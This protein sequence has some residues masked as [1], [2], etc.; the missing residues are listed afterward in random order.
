[1]AKLYIVNN[2]S[3]YTGPVPTGFTLHAPGDIWLRN[4]DEVILSNTLSSSVN[5]RPERGYAQS[6]ADP[7]VSLE[8]G[9]HGA[10]NVTTQVWLAREDLSLQI[11]VPDDTDARSVNIS[12]SGTDGSDTTVGSN[13]SIGNVTGGNDSG[14]NDSLTVGD[15]SSVGTINMGNGDNYV[16]IGDN[17]TLNGASNAIIIGSGNDRVFLGEGVVAPNPIF[18]GPGSDTV[19]AST[20]DFAVDMGI[21]RPNATS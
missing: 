20:G 11:Q 19:G 15:G 8:Q 1:M 3:T 16:L 10:Y 4:G 6:E 7:V 9:R 18:T 5:F 21:G 2:P 17:V 12:A 14:D 13:S